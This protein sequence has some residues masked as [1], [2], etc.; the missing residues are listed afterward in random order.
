MSNKIGSSTP[1]ALGLVGKLKGAS[2]QP[3]TTS[4]ASAAPAAAID[5]VR[6][7]GDAV[8]LQQLDKGSAKSP[9]IDTQRIAKAR[10]AIASGSYAIDAQQIAA[11]LTR[12]DWDLGGK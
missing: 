2:E 3:L 1:V 7:T 9:E 5:T 11:K 6:L 12:M 8:R 10:A 4:V